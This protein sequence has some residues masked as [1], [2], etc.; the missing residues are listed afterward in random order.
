MITPRANA[1]IE[2][3]EANTWLIH[4][5]VDGVS[6]EASLLQPQFQA[7]CL[8]WVL[9]HIVWRRN[10]ALETLGLPSVWDESIS[11]CYCTGSEP[12]HT[13]EGAR[14]FS[15]L[16]ADLDR[17]QQALSAALENTSEASLDA[18]FENE[19]GAKP[20][21]EHLQGFHWHETYH[22][23]QLDLLRAFIDGSSRSEL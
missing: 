15:D 19:Q 10:S 23:G 16:L 2:D 12:V 22:L 4:R 20:V 5:H 11:A 17:S 3:Y 14:R 7:N 13:Q 18:V 1:L 9:G 8:N 21:F 6:D